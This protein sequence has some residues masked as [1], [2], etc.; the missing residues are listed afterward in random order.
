MLLFLFL[1]GVCAVGGF[2]VMSLI[3]ILFW[4]IGIFKVPPS[5]RNLFG[6]YKRPAVCT[7]LPEFEQ[8]SGMVVIINFEKTEDPAFVGWYETGNSTPASGYA[9]LDIPEQ[10][11]MAHSHV[12]ATD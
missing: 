4:A 10:G 8:Q 12:A 5:V 3:W 7:I 2:L 1:L 9:P 6:A 11:R